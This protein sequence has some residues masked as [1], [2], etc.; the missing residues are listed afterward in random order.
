V[1]PRAINMAGFTLLPVILAMSLIAAI[2]FLLNRDS[3]MNAGMIA[4]QSD[5]D[6]A[7]YTAEAGLQAVNA[8]TQAKGCTGYTNLNTTAFGAGSYTA[9]VT[10]AS[11]TPVTLTAA[12]TTAGG[13]SASLTRSNVVVHPTTPYTI[14]LQPG[15]TGLDTYI[16][17]SGPNT[18]YGADNVL[19]I[20]TGGTVALVQFDLSSIPAGS[21]IRSAQF[22]LSHATGGND[23]VSAFTLTTPWTAGTG[24]AMSGAT[25]NTYDGNTSWA[26]AGGGGD[27]NRASGVAITLP[28]NGQWATWDLTALTAAWSAGTQPNYGIVLAATTAGASDSFVSSDDP[29]NLAQHPTLAVTFLPPWCGWVP[30]ATG[31]T[32]TLQATQDTWIDEA[33]AGIN[34][35]I[36][37]SFKVTTATATKKSGHG[38]VQ[39]DLSSIP[40]GTTLKSATL[41]LFIENGNFSSNGNPISH[42]T[43][44]PVNNYI[45]WTE[46]FV[47]WNR[48]N[49]SPNSWGCANGGGGCFG[50]AAASATLSSTFTSGW[51]E[52]NVKALAQ[53]WL[54]GS[55]P[56]YGAGVMM[57]T[58]AQAVFDSRESTVNQNQNRPQLLITY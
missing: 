32:V 18:N 30:P 52:W 53:Q 46:K 37:N 3:G 29:S 22:S 15:T 55:V 35:G 51:V 10:P 17:S 9:T 25:W 34:Y 38:L 36:L 42:I 4:S 1:S 40:A 14:T 44:Y 11:G 20:A 45:P 57:D 47:T 54:D 28:G 23:M 7:R 56:N 24:A 49:G 2:A 41:Q 19:K 8:L 58:T 33:N 48:A 6:R 16:R 13:A 31:T 50:A 12:A 43:V 26:T 5:A 39:F 21:D 27:Y